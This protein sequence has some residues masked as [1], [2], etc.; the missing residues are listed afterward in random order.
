MIAFALIAP[1]ARGEESLA[2]RRAVRGVPVDDAV[3]ESPELRELR[4]FEEQAFP[5]GGVRRSAAPL[6][7]RYRHPCPEPGAAAATFRPSC[8]RPSRATAPACAPRQI[9]SGSAI[10]KLPDLPVRWEPQV[11][12]YLDY[13][14]NDPRDAP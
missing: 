2:E 6:T 14:K 8:A 10:P 3:G 11:L 9:P 5:R 4:R 7:V 13:F 1:G 12:R